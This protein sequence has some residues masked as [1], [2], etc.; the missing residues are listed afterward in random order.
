MLQHAP[1][2]AC[3][4]GLSQCA[5]SPADGSVISVLGQGI[6]KV[7]KLIDGTLKLLTAALGKRDPASI[8]CQQWIPPDP[9]ENNKE[10]LLLGTTDGEIV[11]LE[12]GGIGK[13]L[14]RSLSLWHAC[15]I[16]LRSQSILVTASIHL[17][18]LCRARMP[19]ASSAPRTASPSRALPATPRALSSARTM[20]S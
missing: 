16:D 2:K 7:F 6:F 20:A 15:S 5:F 8:V 19:A 14:P 11:M 1:P 12:V 9:S 17:C 4:L 3:S 10:R 18:A 13:G